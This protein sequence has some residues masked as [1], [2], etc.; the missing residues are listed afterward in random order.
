VENTSNRGG[1]SV[2]PVER[3]D[4]LTDLARELGL[5]S[6]LDG[7]RIFNAAVASGQPAARI[8]RG[9]DTVSVCLSKGLGAPVGSLLCGPSAL[10]RQARRVRK[11]LGGG[12]R[13]AG[14]L[15]AAGLYAF[16][17][18]VERLADDHAR[19][20]VL[21]E[22]L[23]DAGWRVE[24]P[25]ETNMVYL[26]VDDAPGLVGRL[27]QAG[28]LCAAVAPDRVRLVTHLDVGDAELARALTV[29]AGVV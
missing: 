17:F 27:A 19:A 8:A 5:A 12:M 23:R 14:I 21:W 3:L 13:Q 29:F 10:V 22:G 6:H 26:Q 9:F 7:A 25:P 1:G 24:S 28:L 20:R 4:A 15:A 18:H 16:E 11:L 2:Y